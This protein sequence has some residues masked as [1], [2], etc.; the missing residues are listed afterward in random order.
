L[1]HDIDLSVAYSF[2]NFVTLSAGYSYMRG[3]KTM[4]ILQNTTDSRR[5]HWGWL[6]LTVTPTIFT[7]SWND[8]KK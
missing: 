4:E 3:T 6:M 5:L 7:Y 8:K 1:G 2:A